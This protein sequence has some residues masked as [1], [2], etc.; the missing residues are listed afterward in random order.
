[1]SRYPDPHR[2]ALAALA[3]CEQVRHE[4]PNDVYRYLEQRCATEPEQMT[5]I[6]MC[7]A[8]WMDY[9]GPLSTLALRAEAIAA[10]RRQAVS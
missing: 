6:T 1:M 2:V 8:I 3:V 5:Q 7:L 4:D 9:E 10:N